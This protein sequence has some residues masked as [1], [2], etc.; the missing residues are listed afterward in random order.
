MGLYPSSTEPK[1]VS[2]CPAYQ[3]LKTEESVMETLK[4]NKGTKIKSKQNKQNT[5]PPPKN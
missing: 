1:Y 5:H 4:L 3:I 2:F